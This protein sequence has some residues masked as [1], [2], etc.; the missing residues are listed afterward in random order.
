MHAHHVILAPAHVA[1]VDGARLLFPKQDLARKREI[2]EHGQQ[3]S[4]LRHVPDRA[5]DEERLIDEED[6]AVLANVT[7]E[8][9]SA[10]VLHAH[11]LCGIGPVDAVCDGI[12]VA[13]ALLT[14][15]NRQDLRARRSNA[16]CRLR[17]SS[18]AGN[19]HTVAR[20]SAG[21]CSPG[22]ARLMKKPDKLLG[23][24]QAYRF[25]WDVVALAVTAALMLLVLL[26]R[27]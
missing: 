19:E 16:G 22:F 14:C 6:L 13:R 20:R 12:T 17:Q 26:G 11:V 8:S 1:F 27:P 24:A 3:R 25:R 9:G 21:C 5:F 7:A 18:R 4:V 23:I 2:D 15:P 10:I